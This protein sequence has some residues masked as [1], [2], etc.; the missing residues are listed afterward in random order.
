MTKEQYEEQEFQELL[1]VKRKQWEAQ[2][3]DLARHL[4]IEKGC[5]P[6]A[7]K[8]EV[9]L[10]ENWETYEHDAEQYLRKRILNKYYWECLCNPHD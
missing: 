5:D 6:D 2:V 3:E 8:S 9:R 10:I 4:C 1:T 7:K